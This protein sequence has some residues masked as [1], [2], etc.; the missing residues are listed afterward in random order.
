MTGS[1]NF[2]DLNYNLTFKGK[3]MF[4]K[5]I[6]HTTHRNFLKRQLVLISIFKKE[7][8][9]QTKNCVIIFQVPDKF[10]YIEMGQV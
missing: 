4:S 1:Q 5:I 6:V 10:G 7:N 8:W 9:C 3:K 2:K